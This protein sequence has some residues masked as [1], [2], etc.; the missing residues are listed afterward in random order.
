MGSLSNTHRP[1]CP[2]H[3]WLIHSVWGLGE[4]WERRTAGL[5]EGQACRW[6][7]S[8]PSPAVQ[9]PFLQLPKGQGRKGTNMGTLIRLI[10]SLCSRVVTIRPAVWEA[11]G[12][13][14]GSLK[15]LAPCRPI[16]SQAPTLSLGRGAREGSFLGGRVPHMAS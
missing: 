5:G 16:L 7:P 6:L 11:L 9:P 14:Q 15:L 3:L 2:C 12:T 8:S 13:R 1:E 10:N 4:R